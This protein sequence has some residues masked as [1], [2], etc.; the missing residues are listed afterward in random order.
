MDTFREIFS[1]LP[2]SASQE[3]VLLPPAVIGQIE[4]IR[5]RCGQLPRILY[6][7]T[8][9]TLTRITTR[10]DL[11]KTLHNLIKFAVC[12]SHYD[13][14][15]FYSSDDAFHHLVLHRT[16]VPFCYVLVYRTKLLIYFT[17]TC[18]VCYNKRIE[19]IS[20]SFIFIAETCIY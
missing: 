17:I 3:L 16:I 9:K 20:S 13:L 1:R 8:E 10:E 14:A 15:P 4:E 18:Q 2:T 5:L 7:K 11:Q 6:G 19:S 12:F